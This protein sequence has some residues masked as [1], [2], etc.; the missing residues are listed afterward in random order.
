M[1][2]R[3]PPDF[4]EI[5]KKCPKAMELWELFM[6]HR[7][8]SNGWHEKMVDGRY[9]YRLMPKEWL[10]G[11]LM[12]FFAGHGIYMDAIILYTGE[13]IIGAYYKT[14][15]ESLSTLGRKKKTRPHGDP[16]DAFLYGVH[17][18]FDALEEQ[19]SKRKNANRLDY[20]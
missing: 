17:I 18:C 12:K 2:N 1:A 16:C 15:K 11:S 7:A 4:Y 9:Y 13:S 20:K 10:L 6:D 8:L 5:A 3:N 19:L 14:T